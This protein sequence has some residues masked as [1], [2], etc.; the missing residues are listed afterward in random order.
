MNI[1]KKSISCDGNISQGPIIYVCYPSEEF[2]EGKWILAVNSVSF[3]AVANFSSTCAI[4]CN[5]VTCRKRTHNGDIKIVEEPLNIFHLKTT[6][7]LPRSISRF[8]KKLIAIFHNPN[9][10]YNLNSKMF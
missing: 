3:E 2:S 6:T 9:L 1:A 5:F 8:C 10:L 4:T 7:T